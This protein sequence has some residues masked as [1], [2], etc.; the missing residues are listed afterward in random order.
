MINQKILYLRKKLDTVDTKLLLSLKKRT[1]LVNQIVKLKKNKQDIV[2]KK[3][4]N[5]I[6]RKIKK[7]SIILKIDPTITASIWKEMI[8][9]FIRYEYKKFKK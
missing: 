5:F 4:I 9:S 8:K 7:K 6:L 1:N 3:R 2:D